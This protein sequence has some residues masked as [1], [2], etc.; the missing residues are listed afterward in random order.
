MKTPDLESDR[1][2][3]EL[4]LTALAEQNLRDIAETS[5]PANVGPAATERATPNSSLKDPLQ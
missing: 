2:L 5:Y 4:L 3:I 1:S